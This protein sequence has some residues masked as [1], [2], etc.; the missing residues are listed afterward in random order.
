M[1][2]TPLV[3]MLAVA[4]AMPAHAAT[5][6][7]KPAPTPAAPAAPVSK[8]LGGFDAWNAYTYTEN[9]GR[10]C[11]LVGDPRRMEPAGFKRKFPTAM[12]THRPQESVT[13]VISFTEGYTLKSGSDAGLDVGGTKFDLF[14]NGDTAWSRTADLDKTIVEAMIKGREAVLTASPEKG[15]SQTTDVYPLAGFSKALALIDKA[16]GVKR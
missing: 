9:S 15:P 13:D 3:L 7:K 8:R 10:V 4:V 2:L 16:C 1:R 12:V 14:T 6:K 11:Y 5:K